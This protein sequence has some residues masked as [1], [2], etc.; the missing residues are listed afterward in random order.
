MEKLI[1][2]VSL[3][4]LLASAVIMALVRKR[5]L[6]YSRQMGECLDAMIAG[7]KE[8]VFQEEE[9]TLTGKLQSKLHRLCEILDQKSQENEIQRR[10]LETMVADISHQVKTPIANVRMYHS[11]LEKKNLDEEKRQQFL[12]AAERQTDKLEFLMKSM[13]K[14]SRLENGIVKV[15][16]KEN[17]IRQLLEQAV[18]DVALKADEK[19]IHIE[20]ACEDSLKAVFD[21]KWTLEAV[22]NILDNAVKYTGVGGNIRIQA[23]VTDFYNFS[24]I[25]DITTN[26]D[27]YL[28]TSHYMP[29]VGDRM[30]DVMFKGQ[31]DERLL[32]QG[33]GYR[34]TCG[35][36]EEFLRKYVD[37]AGQNGDLA[38]NLH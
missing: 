31:V 34:V 16:P 17:S 24:G 15:Q 12:A 36:C 18:C 28:E 6:Q 21:R 19:Q 13:I 30:L 2:A 26:N 10:Q 22:F 35:N 25:N 11:L 29:Q 5:L 9:D 1:L 33:F 38:M 14:M 27:N 8:I 20:M 7:S 4:C 3:I 32:A 37:G 23:Q